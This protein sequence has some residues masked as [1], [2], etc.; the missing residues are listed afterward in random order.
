MN[1]AK[2]NLSRSRVYPLVASLFLYLTACFHPGTV[3]K[4]DSDAITKDLESKAHQLDSYAQDYIV[5]GR[6]DK[7]MYFLF[8]K[9]GKDFYTFR[10][11]YN[12]KGKRLIRIFNVEGKYDYDYYPDEK[13]AVRYPTKG[14]WN[15]TNYNR[16]KKW[17]F[18]YSG[19]RVIGEKTVNGKDC[20]VLRKDDVTI[21]VWKEKGLPTSLVSEKPMKSELEYGNFELNLN[22]NLFSIPTGTRIIERPN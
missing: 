21:T 1:Y 12:E 16:A 7:R 6:P 8:K 9:N 22:E 5:L 11:D 19:F 3:Q 13:V 18:D 2:N 15:E 17:H 20:Y 14:S 4:Y 10:S